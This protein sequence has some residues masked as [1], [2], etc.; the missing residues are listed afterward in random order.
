MNLRQKLLELA[1]Q[2]ADENGDDTEGWDSDQFRAY[3]LD[4]ADWR[5]VL[6]ISWRAG[7]FAGIEEWRGLYY[8]FDD[9]DIYGPYG[10]F[11]EARSKLQLDAACDK[12]AQR[13][14]LPEYANYDHD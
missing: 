4:A 5:S 10:S 11:Q 13:W 2:L 1:S 8:A 9:A 7:S 14:V 12:V 3:L 6:R